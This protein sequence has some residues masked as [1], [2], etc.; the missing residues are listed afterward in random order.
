MIDAAPLSLGI[1]QN[2][3]E[4]TCVTRN[5]YEVNDILAPKVTHVQEITITEVEVTGDL[6]IAITIYYTTF[7]ETSWRTSSD[8][9]ALENQKV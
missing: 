1:W 3:P 7:Q 6:Q 9:T 2:A 5:L 8:W 4:L